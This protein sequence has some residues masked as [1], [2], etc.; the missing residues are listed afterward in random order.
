MQQAELLKEIDD[1][2]DEISWLNGLEGVNICDFVYYMD[3]LLAHRSKF[4]AI[5]DEMKGD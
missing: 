4:F 5:L 1:I 2:N 3:I